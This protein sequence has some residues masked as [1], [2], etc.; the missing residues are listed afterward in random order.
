MKEMLLQ[1]TSARQEK[2]TYWCIKEDRKLKVTLKI[3]KGTTNW[4][5]QVNVC[6][7]TKKSTEGIG[8][9]IQKSQTKTITNTQTEES[10]VNVG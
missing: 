8:V 2:K 3:E 1:N 9:Y 7:K 6:D 10:E 4:S 5:K